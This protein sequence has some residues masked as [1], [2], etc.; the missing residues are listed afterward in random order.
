MAPIEI[1]FVGTFS[2]DLRGGKQLDSMEFR[3]LQVGPKKPGG[4]RNLRYKMF[5]FGPFT[6]D[7]TTPI[8]DEDVR[9]PIWQHWDLK[10]KM[11]EALEI[12]FG[13]FFAAFFCSILGG[14]CL[15]QFLMFF[16]RSADVCFYFPK[17]KVFLLEVKLEMHK[18][19]MNKKYNYT[20]Y[21]F[22]TAYIYIY[23][24]NFLYFSLMG[25]S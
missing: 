5:F 2:Y 24:Y 10:K 21:V 17:M 23:I 25:W 11:D 19:K 9:G 14:S 12:L 7:T 22:F 8:Y 1:S 6:W 16:L 4:E 13:S 3:T 18:D 15:V 20:T